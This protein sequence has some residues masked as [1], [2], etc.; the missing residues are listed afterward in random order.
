[1]NTFN[2]IAAIFVVAGF[3]SAIIIACDLIRRKQSM[4]I[5]N[6]V[7]ILTG[8]WA[9][10]LGLWAYFKFGRAGKEMEDAMPG[11]KM[12]GTNDSMGDMNMKA[13]SM[14]GMD[15]MS[16]MKM[17][18]G[19]V[20]PKWQSVTLS[21]LHC[22]AGCTLADIIGETFMLFVPVVIA[23][24]ALIGGW[25]FDYILALA[26]GVFFQFAA[27]RAMEKIPFGTAIS[28]AFKADVLSLTA[29]QVGMYGWMA[30]AIFGFFQGSPLPKLSWSFWFMMQVAML[31]GFICAYPVNILLI[32][33]GIKKGM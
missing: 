14:K 30:I 11:M 8:L 32:K 27:I 19:P 25:V 29:W 6:S 7:W 3:I 5:M 1:M 20:R 24:S 16:G 4:K 22:G 15:G 2:T 23:G 21:T 9:S 13:A 31:C 28:K 17:D 33:A 18:I 26:I 12:D 10:V